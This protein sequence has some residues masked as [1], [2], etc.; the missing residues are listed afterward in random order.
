MLFFL[1]DVRSV[2]C[3][4]DN[5]AAIKTFLK[6]LPCASVPPADHGTEILDLDIV[7]RIEFVVKKTAHATK[8]KRV[9]VQV[10]PHLLYRVSP[11]WAP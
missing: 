8:R 4:D 11:V 7:Q 9:K 2:N 6:S 3:R 10:K 1:K 5:I